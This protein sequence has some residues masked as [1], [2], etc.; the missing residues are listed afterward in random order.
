MNKFTIPIIVIL[1]IAAGIGA[2]FIFQK[3]AP[4][5]GTLYVLWAVHVEGDMQECQIGQPCCKAGFYQ[6]RAFELIDVQGLEYLQSLSENHIDSFGGHPKMY[7][8]PAGEFIETEMDSQYGSKAFRKYDWLALGHEIGPQPHKIYWSGQ[9]FCWPTR[10]M[11]KEGIIKKLT[12]LHQWAEKWYHNGQKVNHGLTYAPGMKL[13]LPIFGKDLAAKTEAE[14][15]IDKEAYKI[16]YRISMEDWDAYVADNP[17]LGQRI[18]YL[19]QANYDD[20]TTMYKIGFQGSVR[21]DC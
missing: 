8:S 16:G 9:K 11:S 21:N 6:E 17:A 13:E 15:F 19:Y 10:E 18:P 5:E 12:T 2:Y 1:I 14:K 3:P 7:L 20:G 4:S